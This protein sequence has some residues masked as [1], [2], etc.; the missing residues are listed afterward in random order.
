M[1][2][3]PARGAGIEPGRAAR[4]RGAKRARPSPGERHAVAVWVVH[5]APGDRP[6]A[7]CWSQLSAAERERADRYRDDADRTRFCVARALLRS[8]LAELT[9][10][11]PRDVP[12]HQVRGGPVTLAG[13]APRPSFSVAHGG[14]YVVV[15][16][17]WRPVGVDVE[18]VPAVAPDDLLLHRSLG[19]SEAAALRA[20]DGEHRRRAFATRWAR[21]EALVKAAGPAASGRGHRGLAPPRALDGADAVEAVDRRRAPAAGR[22]W[23]AQELHLGQDHAGVV[24][25]SGRWRLQLRSVERSDLV[26]TPG[27]PGPPDQR[28]PAHG[29][30]CAVGDDERAVHG[31]ASGGSDAGPPRR[32]AHA[33]RS[34]ARLPRAAQVVG[35]YLASELAIR[36]LPLGRAARL[37]GVQLATGATPTTPPRSPGPRPALSA[38]ELRDL[39]LARRVG[40]LWPAPAGPCLREAL[41][42]GHLARRHAP[43]LVIGARLDDGA[44]ARAHAWLELDDGTRLGEI[45]GFH[46]LRG[47]DAGAVL[48][49]ADSATSLGG[50]ARARRLLDG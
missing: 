35:W 45:D 20:L 25:A 14:R 42:A 3:R 47:R 37:F 43:R 24:L 15:A 4:P 28:R 1:S 49:A 22:S 36:L 12:L 30:L 50:E 23:R 33:G 19:A 40:R 9:G 2:G 46:A 48:P 11:A 31:P 18:P 6:S 44:G 5:L 21:A 39:G 10:I 8:V 32:L 13:G 26:A 27:D 34:V 7:T 29:S 17:A 41:V 38:V 16:R